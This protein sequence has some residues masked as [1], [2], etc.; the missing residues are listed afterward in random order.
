MTPLEETIQRLMEP[1]RRGD[2]GE[3]TRTVYLGDTFT[4]PVQRTLDALWKFAEGTAA[5]SRDSKDYYDSAVARIR[6]LEDQ[7]AQGA[8]MYDAEVAETDALKLRLVAASVTNARYRLALESI[9]KAA[10]EALV[11]TPPG[12]DPVMLAPWVAGTAN[13]ALKR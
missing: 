13:E 4:R 12:Q 11:E 9:A 3:P 10:V 2:K 5:A 8:S 1:D 6:E 7:L